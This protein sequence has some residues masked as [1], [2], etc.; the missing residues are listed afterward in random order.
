MLGPRR[1]A[2]GPRRA[3]SKRARGYGGLIWRITN[4]RPC[5]GRHRHVDSE[6]ALEVA[7][8]VEHLDAPV[9]S[10]GYIDT[11][12]GVKRDAMGRV[13]LTGAGAALAPGLNPVTVLVDLGHTRVDIPVAD[14]AVAG[15]I[16]RHVGHLAEAAR[17]GGKRRIRMLERTGLLIGRLLL[18]PEDHRYAAV[19]RELDDHV[20]AFVGD[21]D[22]VLAIHLDHMRERPGIEVAADLADEPAVG[23]EL[24]E[25]S[26]SGTVGRARGVAPR[27]H[28]DMAF[29]VQR[30][31]RTFTEIGITRQMHWIRNRVVG[32]GADRIGVS[33]GGM[34]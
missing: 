19:G 16:P 7:F 27:Q 10:V 13:E 21:P 23:C 1:N 9:A 4:G 32:D 20:R 17:L 22:I 18:A 34:R 8:A 11:S 25:L 29:G 30:D 15:G 2:D 6:L 33:V 14:V 26:G 28:E 24:K 3:G 12:L 31:A 5:S